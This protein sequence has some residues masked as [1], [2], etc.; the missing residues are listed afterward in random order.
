MSLLLFYVILALLVSFV[1]SIMEATLLSVSNSYIKKLMKEGKKS[2]KIL[3]EYK[4]DVDRPLAAILTLN[5]IANTLG[6]TGA[7]AQAETVFGNK[8]VTLFAVALTLAILIFSEIIPKTVGAVYWRKT[9]PPTAFILKAIIFL[10]WPLIW[11]TRV[12]VNIIPKPG[13]TSPKIFREEIS[14]LAEI[15][16]DMG[17]LSEWEEDIITNL[18]R[19]SKIKVND[20][21]TPRTVIFALHMNKTAGEVIEENKILP[22]SRIPVYDEDTDDIKGIVLRYAIMEA[23]AKDTPDI[24]MKEMLRPLHAIPKSLNVA[25]VLNL[26]IQR[27]EHIFLVIDEYGGTQGIVTLEDSMEALLGLEIVDEKDRVV[28]MRELAM[29]IWKSMVGKNKQS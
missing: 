7:G 18:L 25:E 16:E 23:V 6:A 4:K 26:F 2:G 12:V 9:A 1:C 29:R 27:G 28:D 20:I 15:G 17:A 22:F 21:L 5:T 14:V 8:W 3:W 19:L 10:L 11:L 24:T 13:K